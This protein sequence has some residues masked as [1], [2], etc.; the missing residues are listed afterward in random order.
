MKKQLCDFY[1]RYYLPE[2]ESFR[3]INEECY[4]FFNDELYNKEIL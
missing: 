3:K 2:I 4:Y 1:F